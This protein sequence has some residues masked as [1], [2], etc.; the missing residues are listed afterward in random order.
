MG[1][2]GRRP[3]SPLGPKR[4]ITIYLAPEEAAYLEQLSGTV[5][6]GLFRLV[7]EA[8]AA[9]VAGAPSNTVEKGQP[10]GCG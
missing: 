7:R 5:K 9:V 8:M 2:S 1:R 10:P 6:D 4:Q 3:E